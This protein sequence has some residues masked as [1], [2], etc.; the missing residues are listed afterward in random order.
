MSPVVTPGTFETRETGVILKRDGRPSGPD[1][2]TIDLVMAPE[3]ARTGG[4]IQ[5]GSQITVE[6]GIIGAKQQNTY[7][8][9][10]PMADLHQPQRHD[11]DVIWDG[12]TV[13]MGGLIREELN[14]HQGPRC[15][16]SADI[17][18]L[19]WLFRSE[20]SYSQKKNLLIFVTARLVDPAGRPIHTGENMALPGAGIEAAPAAEAEAAAAP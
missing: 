11:V 20:G 3:V 17:P 16:S 19:G 1:G 2:Y 13:V 12:Q 7:L 18:V 10:M 6:T 15:R 9:N 14:H 5:Y 4:W 8:F